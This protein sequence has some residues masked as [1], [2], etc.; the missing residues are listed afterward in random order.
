M[1]MINSTFKPTHVRCVMVPENYDTFIS[2]GDIFEVVSISD[3]A[4]K[5]RCLGS[6]HEFRVYR[7]ELKSSTVKVYDDFEF[8][9]V[10]P[11]AILGDPVNE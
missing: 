8:R 11:P 6:K 7:N 3:E 2:V 1:T 10:G 9:Y 5:V 4:I